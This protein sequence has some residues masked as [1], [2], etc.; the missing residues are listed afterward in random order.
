MRFV[1]WGMTILSV[2]IGLLALIGLLWRVADIE[3]TPAMQTLSGYFEYLT[4]TLRIGLFDWW[5]LP[6]LNAKMPDWT[7]NA[8]VLWALLILWSV[9]TLRYAFTRHA[10]VAN[11]MLSRIS[12][13]FAVILGAIST[14]LLAIMTGLIT[15]FLA[16]L[17]WFERF[18]ET[19]NTRVL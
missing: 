11:A 2:L 4:G 3:P 19:V 10:G 1:S 18:V 8:L 15:E 17:D 14:F 13:V 5:T 12:R 9:Q 7:V 16:R 6:T